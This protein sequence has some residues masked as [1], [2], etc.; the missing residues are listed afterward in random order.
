MLSDSDYVPDGSDIT[1][2]TSEEEEPPETIIESIFD[3]WEE[4]DVNELT[5]NLYSLMDEYYETNLLYISSPKFYT[6]MLEYICQIIFH[7]LLAGNL[8]HLEDYDEIY[9]F[10]ENTLEVY[11]DFSNQLPAR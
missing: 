11:L 9:E 7:D 6:D 8:C 4:D 10:A 1:T 5:N 2:V 3:T